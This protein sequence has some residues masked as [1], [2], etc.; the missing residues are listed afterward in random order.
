MLLSAALADGTATTN[1]G[2]VYA[3]GGMLGIRGGTL[4]G[5]KA[6]SGGNLYVDSGAAVIQTDGAVIGGTATTNGGNLYIGGGA[7][8]TLQGGSV[9][10]GVITRDGA[11]NI[12]ARGVLTVSGGRI[13]GGV[14]VDSKGKPVAASN[15]KINV[16]AYQAQATL[17]GGQIDGGFM[18]YT[19]TVLKLSGDMVVD[20]AQ[21]GLPGL[22]LN[23]VVIKENSLT[24]KARVV[25][26]NG[27]DTCISAQNIKTGLVSQLG[28][29]LSAEA[30]GKLYLRA[31]GP[32]EA[33][34]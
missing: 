27:A 20:G 6:A 28:L 9:E 31:S 13:T 1:G 10:K 15:Q 3:G 32:A 12:D 23:G 18:A 7:S 8:Y 26:S 21:A 17:A 4:E 22:T 5:G 34:E 30:D 11:A 14:R 25:V 24:E 33:E 29:V 2:N 16:F 19:G